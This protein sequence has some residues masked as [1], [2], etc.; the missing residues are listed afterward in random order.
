MSPQYDPELE[1]VTCK[2]CNGNGKFLNSTLRPIP[3]QDTRCLQCN[4]YGHVWRKVEPQV[5]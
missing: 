2:P 5:P 3:E 1:V 4:G